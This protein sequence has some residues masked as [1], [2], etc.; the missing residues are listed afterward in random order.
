MNELPA[1]RKLKTHTISVNIG[2]ASKEL[3][4]APKEIIL[5]S[6][7]K[8][9]AAA[10]AL[11]SLRDENIKSKIVST[12][13]T[14]SPVAT[15]NKK[16]RLEPVSFDSGSDRNAPLRN[17]LNRQ[18]SKKFKKEFATKKSN[19]T[20][21]SIGGIDTI[22]KE[23]CELMHHI[24][25]PQMYKRMDLP[26][27]RGFLLHGPP[28]SGKTLLANAIAGVCKFLVLGI[29]RIVFSLIHAGDSPIELYWIRR[30][31]HIHGEL[32][33]SNRGILYNKHLIS[34]QIL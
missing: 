24:N 4:K 31:L 8:T 18:L 16:R 30:K 11:A 28:G 14:L 27:P 20:F 2:H 21:A 26:A 19:Y 1:K 22:L 5:S 13:A 33:Q 34:R 7:S 6:V 29:F 17:P 23:L 12:S 9:S 25:N 15:T 32:N 3:S 10:E